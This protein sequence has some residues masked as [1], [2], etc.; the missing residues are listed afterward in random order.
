[1]TADMSSKN[2]KTNADDMNEKKN[3]NPSI[4]P[5]ILKDTD[6]TLNHE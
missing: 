1:M 4:I 3:I 2:K 5:D 6:A